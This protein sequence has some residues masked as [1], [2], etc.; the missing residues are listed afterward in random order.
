MTQAA[1]RIGAERLAER[2]EGAGA[3]DELGRLARTLNEMLARLEAGFA[4]IRR[5]SA[6]ASTNSGRH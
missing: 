4:Q 3:D 2:L 6:D 5:F 1:R